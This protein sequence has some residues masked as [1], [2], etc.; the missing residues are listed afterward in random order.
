MQR[1]KEKDGWVNGSF[2]EDEWV[3]GD[4]FLMDERID[5]CVYI[6]VIC[7]FSVTIH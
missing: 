2:S 4:L 3:N 5:G 6:A 1:V 7:N